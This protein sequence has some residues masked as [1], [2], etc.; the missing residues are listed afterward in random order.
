LADIEVGTTLDA[1]PYL[2]SLYN[3][4]KA[5]G[6]SVEEIN[7]AFGAIG[8]TLKPIYGEV[9]LFE[10]N[11]DFNKWATMTGLDQNSAAAE[12]YK[13]RMITS[14]EVVGNNNQVANNLPSSTKS[15]GS[16]PSKKDTKDNIKADDH[17]DR[18]KEINDVLDDINDTYEKLNSQTDRYF[19]T[20]RIQ[21]LKNESEA[22]KLV[23]QGLRKKYDLTEQY[24]KSDKK[25][26]EAAGFT[27][28]DT[29]GNITNYEERMKE[30]IA[31]VNSA[32]N[33]YNAA[34]NNYNGKITEDT[35]SED[36]EDEEK[37][38]ESK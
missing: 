25:A 2:N 15:G 18:Y 13:V 22:L 5:T 11:D 28:D 4:L 24:L 29:F 27:V 26:L 7:E 33:E 17:I 10:S 37:A 12:F 20:N 3:M 21:A 14:Y 1:T 38:I 19:G 31:G 30:L 8:F 9:S 32:I 34:V 6:A 16:S 36:M 23:N 35:K